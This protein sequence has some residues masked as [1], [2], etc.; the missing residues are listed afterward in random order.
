MKLSTVTQSHANE[1]KHKYD[2]RFREHF[3]Q[4]F[5]SQNTRNGVSGH[6]DFKIFWGS[7]HVQDPPSGSPLQGSPDSSVIKQNTHLYT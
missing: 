3:N 6:Q 4:I 5:A 7:M 1:I 2:N